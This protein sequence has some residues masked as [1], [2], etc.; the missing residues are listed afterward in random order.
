MKIAEATANKGQ[1][2]HSSDTLH[3]VNTLVQDPHF[4]G[5]WG[6]GDRSSLHIK[7]TLYRILQERESPVRL[8]YHLC[9]GLSPNYH[10]FLT[11]TV[12]VWTE[13]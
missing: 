1:H 4:E 6:Q 9:H 10:R 8:M 5:T 11:E 3:P 2:L 7:R 13:G 12:S